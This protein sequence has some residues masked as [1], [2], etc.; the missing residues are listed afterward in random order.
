MPAVQFQSLIPYNRKK[1]R[2][3]DALDL[4]EKLLNVD[5]KERITAEDALKH[6]FFQMVRDFDEQKRA[7]K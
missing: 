5:H 3:P 2:D 1:Y 7:T 4:L 6:P